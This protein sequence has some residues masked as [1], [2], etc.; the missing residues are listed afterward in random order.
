MSDDEIKLHRGLREVYI[1][2]TTSS[3]I[4]GK[5]GKLYYRGYNIDDLAVNCG[6]EE[7]IYLIMNG[8]LPTVQELEQFNSELHSSMF[9]PDPVIDII[10]SIK[11]AHPM[12][13]LRTAIS[14]LSAFDEDVDDNSLEATLRKGTRLTAQAP[15]IVTYHA[16][17]R[18]GKDPIPPD[19]SLSLAA[20]FLYMLFGEKPDPRDVALIDKDFVL[21]AE[22]GLNASSFGARVAASTQADLHC[23]ITTGVAVLKGPSHGGAAESVMSMSQDI[24]SEDNAENYVKETLSSGGR[25]M[26]FGH[27]VY[28]AVDPRSLHLQDDLKELGERKGE[29]KWYSILQ[30]VVEAMKPYSRRGI[31]QN[32]DFF[33]G[34][35]YFLLNIPEDLFIS[36]FAV[37]RVPGWTAQVVEQFENNILLR[38]R[39]KYVGELDRKFV[40][41]NDR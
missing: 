7:V 13:V 10:R 8:E 32:V 23:A 26:G 38:P 33:S 30:R 11:H 34:A 41:I 19:P 2:R 9:I 5:E 14:A 4:D 31:H 20:N 17:I 25:I 27:R 18:E 39:L 15:T 37:G 22:H 29:P 28:R 1:D 40:K 6:F 35:M 3:F 24:G 12:D 36:I 16:R 21:H